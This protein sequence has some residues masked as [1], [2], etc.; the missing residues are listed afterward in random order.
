MAYSDNVILLTL[1][2]LTAVFN[3][4]HSSGV[5]QGWVDGNNKGSSG[6]SSGGRG[7]PELPEDVGTEAAMMLL[8]EI[9]KGTGN[10]HCH[11]HCVQEY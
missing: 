10:V 1:P 2:I 8:Q 4:G 9:Y 11:E 7:G 5:E 6:T 3:A